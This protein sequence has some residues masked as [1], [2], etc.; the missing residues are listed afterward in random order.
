M[1]LAEA[2][3]RLALLQAKLLRIL[4][5]KESAPAGSETQRLRAAADALAKKRRQSVARAW[6]ALTRAL[7]TRFNDHFT[8]FAAQTSLPNM[9]GPLADGRAFVRYLAQTGDLPE[10]ARL[11][12]LTVDLHYLACPGG[13]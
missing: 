10:A 4:V 9:G 8:E 1:S 6:P 12:A 7:G 11:E 3:T 13:L 5:G 2:R